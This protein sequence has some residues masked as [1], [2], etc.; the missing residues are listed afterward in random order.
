MQEITEMWKRLQIL[1]WPAE[2][3][4]NDELYDVLQIN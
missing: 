4:K 1:S 3:D 2:G